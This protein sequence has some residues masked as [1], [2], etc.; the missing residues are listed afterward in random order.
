M[1]AGFRVAHVAIGSEA[2]PVYADPTVAARGAFE[3]GAGINWYL[4]RLTKLQLA[5]SQTTFD[6][7][8]KA[9]DRRAERYVQARWQGYF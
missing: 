1:Q 8:V 3:V 5:Y 9:G 2:F 7:G 4:T 6:G